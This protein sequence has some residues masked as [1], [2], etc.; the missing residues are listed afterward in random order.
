ML[1]TLCCYIFLVYILS[2]HKYKQLFNI[3]FKEAHRI[4]LSRSKLERMYQEILLFASAD[5][6]VEATPFLDSFAE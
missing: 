4:D 3:K 6:I 5:L 1:F 2:Y